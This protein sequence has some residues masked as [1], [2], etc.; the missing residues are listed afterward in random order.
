MEETPCTLLISEGAERF[1]TEQQV[2]RVEQSY[3]KTQ[4]RY[5]QWLEAKRLVGM[6][7]EWMKAIDTRVLFSVSR[8]KQRSPTRRDRGSG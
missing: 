4:R 3:F 7:S 5:N 2:E 8:T 1:A 6:Q